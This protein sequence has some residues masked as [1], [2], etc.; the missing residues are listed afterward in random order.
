[1]KKILTLAGAL[2]CAAALTL[3]SCAEAPGTGGASAPPAESPTAT[4]AGGAGFK[5]C[6]V[7]DS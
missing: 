5:A 4:G 1:M 3:T 7:S 2:V 6:M